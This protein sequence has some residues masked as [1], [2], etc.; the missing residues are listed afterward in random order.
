MTYRSPSLVPAH[1]HLKELPKGRQTKQ[2]YP[3]QKSLTIG[4]PE[5]TVKACLS[6]LGIIEA[7]GDSF[8]SFRSLS[9]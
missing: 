1:G 8:C 3:L 9:V 2:A 6:I 7:T 4:V 5:Y